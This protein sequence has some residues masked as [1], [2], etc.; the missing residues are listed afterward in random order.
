MFCQ[1]T[2]DF[3]ITVFSS[4]RT[5]DSSIVLK[6]ILDAILIDLFKSLS[7]LMLGIPDR[8]D[9]EGMF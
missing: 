1:K 8:I 5:D 3:E 9:D 6:V 7:N 4:I 2:I